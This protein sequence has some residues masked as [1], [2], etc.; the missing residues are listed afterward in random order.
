MPYDQLIRELLLAQAANPARPQQLQA[1]GVADPA[2]F[3]QAS[4]GKPEQLAANTLRVFLGLQVQCAEC[5]DHPHRHW[6]CVEFWSFASLFANFNGRQMAA[7]NDAAN[8]DDAANVSDDENAD[9]TANAAPPAAGLTIPGTEIV[10]SPL[11]LDGSNP[12]TGAG[13]SP[14][15]ALVHWLTARDNRWFAQAATN[16]LW[17]QLLGRGLVDPAEDLEAAG[18]NDHVDLLAF[19]AQQFDSHDYDIRYLLRAR[20]HPALPVFEPHY[21]FFPTRVPSLRPYALAADDRRTTR[22]QLGPGHRPARG[23]GR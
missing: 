8:S 11:F 14:R 22:R 12:P 13:Q 21:A 4:G 19:V 7:D 23:A 18:P 15:V 9:A 17:E 10:A 3:Y 1:D 5:H 6:N 16:R 2:A 20:Q